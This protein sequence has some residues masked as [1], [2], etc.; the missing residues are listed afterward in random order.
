MRDRGPCYREERGTRR[1]NRR[2]WSSDRFFF[3]RAM[4]AYLQGPRE[5]TY[6]YLIIRE[7]GERAPDGPDVID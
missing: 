2:S 4:P 3:S 5:H 7:I 6:V 1:A